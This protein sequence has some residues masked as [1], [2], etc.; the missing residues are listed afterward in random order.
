LHQSLANALGPT[1]MR[2]VSVGFEQLDG[3]DVCRVTVRPADA[4]VY[5][6][7]GS[8]PRL[9]VRTGNATAPLALDE[10]VQYAASRW[11]GRTTGQ[12]MATALGKRR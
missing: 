12:L 8:E 10:A 2:F 5:L 7:D 1:A 11:R 9:F 4:P 6:R 3:K